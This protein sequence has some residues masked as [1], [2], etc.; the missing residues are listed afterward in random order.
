LVHPHPV[1]SSAQ[2]HRQLLCF[3]RNHAH[4]NKRSTHQA[5]QWWC[6]AWACTGQERGSHGRQGRGGVFPAAASPSELFPCGQWALP[7]LPGALLLL[8]LQ[9]VAAGL[10]PEPA[11]C[12]GP[13]RRGAWLQAHIRKASRVGISCPG[14]VQR[15]AGW[16]CASLRLYHIVYFYSRVGDG[17]KWLAHH[18]PFLVMPC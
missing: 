17:S 16:A 11:R 1:V 5:A 18:I 2:P 9:R 7:C 4:A 3:L 12:S 14:T 10:C 8:Q 15:P 6:S 13:G